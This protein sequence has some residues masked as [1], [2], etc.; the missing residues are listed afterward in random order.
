MAGIEITAKK[1]DKIFAGSYDFG[2]DLKGMSAK[3]GDETVF[4]NA[5]ANMKIVAQA[6]IRRCLEHGKDPTEFL[7]RFI[8]G[9]VTAAAA[10]DPVIAMKAKFATM[11]DEAKKAF[12]ADLKSGK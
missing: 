11:D 3:F 5:R 4:S 1:G 10:V 2:D 7:A 9:T 6:G 12:L 8:P